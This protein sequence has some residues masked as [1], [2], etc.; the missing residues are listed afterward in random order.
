M[1]IKEI[2]YGLGYTLCDNGKPIEIQLNKN[3]KSFPQLRKQILSHELKHWHSKS[4][5]EDFKIDFFDIFSLK[6]SKDKLRFI[7]NHPKALLCNS[8]IFFEN[9]KII[10]NWFV[11]GFWGF[12]SLSLISI[13]VLL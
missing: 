1:K 10:P 9:G 8:P 4:W 6:T 12:I 3:L 13:G 5:F 11:V 2:D 7:K